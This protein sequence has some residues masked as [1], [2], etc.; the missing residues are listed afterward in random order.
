VYAEDEA[1][2]ILSDGRD[3]AGLVA[4]RVAGEPLEWVLGWAWFGT[5]DGDGLRVR[6]HPGVFVPRGRTIELALAAAELLPAGGVAVDLCCGSGAIGAF[7]LHLD[8]TAQ[9]CAA[10]L[11]PTAAD[12]ARENLPEGSVFTGDL[13]EPLP[14]SLRGTIDVIVANTP[15]VPSDQVDLMPPEARD[16]EPLHTLDGGPDGL[17]LLRRIAVDAGDWL[18][19]GGAVLIEINESQYEA[20]ESAFTAAGLSTSA[21]ID[22]D[23]TSV[24]VGQT[25]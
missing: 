8:P 6:V 23:G 3:P 12:C 9:V 15:Y 16:H 5:E 25:A 2:L 10:D 21:R 13:F 22:P 18:R 24:I 17:D 1:R 20:A 19:P 11:D 4:R 7:L 14:D